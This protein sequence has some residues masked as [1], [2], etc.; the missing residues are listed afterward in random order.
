MNRSR[1]LAI[2][3][4]LAVLPRVADS[5]HPLVWSMARENGTT[6]RGSIGCSVTERI[7]RFS[8]ISNPKVDSKQEQLVL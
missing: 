4:V 6:R 5:G 8:Y 7:V 3:P 2:E 1:F